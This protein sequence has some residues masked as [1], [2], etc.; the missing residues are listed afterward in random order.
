MPLR[1][2]AF[3]ATERRAYEQEL[4]AAWSRAEA[5]DERARSLARTLQPTLMPP[6]PPQVNGLDIVAAY[7]PAGR[8]DEVGGDFVLRRE[9]RNTAWCTVATIRL[10]RHGDSRAPTT[11]HAAAARRRHRRAHHGVSEARSERPSGR[12]L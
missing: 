6:V 3:E 8:G 11:C 4:L 1:I 12:M 10:T 9:E 7:R 2:A 5:S